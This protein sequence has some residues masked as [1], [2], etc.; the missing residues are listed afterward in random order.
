MHRYPKP[1]HACS[2]QVLATVL[3]PLGSSS[4]LRAG[5]DPLGAGSGARLL[6]QVAAAGQACAGAGLLQVGLKAL[7]AHTPEHSGTV[8]LLLAAVMQ[9]S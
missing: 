1:T 9:A 2:A 5:D 6:Q 8:P 3:P 7:H 4:E